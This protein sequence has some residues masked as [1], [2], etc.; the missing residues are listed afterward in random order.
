SAY[1]PT[2]EAMNAYAPTA[3]APIG[4]I[5]QAVL[6]NITRG[7]GYPLAAAAIS[8]AASAAIPISVLLRSVNPATTP[9]NTKYAFRSA[10]RTARLSGA[11][12]SAAPSSP[13]TAFTRSASD[14]S[15]NAHPCN[16]EY[17]YGSM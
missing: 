2:L 12:E 7:R 13:R 14:A 4:A 10:R 6:I 11:S 16:A 17:E 8:P 15:P 9:A 1:Q 3:I 5:K